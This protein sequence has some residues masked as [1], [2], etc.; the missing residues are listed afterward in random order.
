MHVLKNETEH[1]EQSRTNKNTNTDARSGARETR[2]QKR[3]S[4]AE[5]TRHGAETIHGAELQRSTGGAL[6]RRRR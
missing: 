5:K 6:K 3:R 2:H 4:T 1:G